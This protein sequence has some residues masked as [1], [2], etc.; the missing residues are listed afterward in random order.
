EV[1]LA[2]AGG[3]RA[4]HA[5]LVLGPLE[6][7]DVAVYRAVELTP[8]RSVGRLPLA[9]DAVTGLDQVQHAELGVEVDAGPG[10]VVGHRARRD[11]GVLCFVSTSLIAS[12]D[13]CR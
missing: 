6:V 9:R 7:H 3:T 12:G 8:T 4:H 1:A 13:P 11:L 10:G 2:L 5:E